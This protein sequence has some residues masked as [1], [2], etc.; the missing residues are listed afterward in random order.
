MEF[1]HTIFFLI[2]LNGVFS[3]AQDIIF[4][5]DSTK[6]IATVM[7]VNPTQIK[8]KLYDDSTGFSIVAFKWN[9]Y[10]IIYKNG[11]QDVF[12]DVKPYYWKVEEDK[13]QEISNKKGIRKRDSINYGHKN[14][15][16]FN[17]VQF[18]DGAIGLNYFRV[19]SKLHMSVSGEFDIGRKNASPLISD[20]ILHEHNRNYVLAHKNSDFNLGANYNFFTKWK[21][22]AYVGVLFRMAQFEGSYSNHLFTINKYYHFLNF[23]FVGKT[24]YGL[25]YS[26]NVAI[27]KY[28]NDYL[29]N[30]PLE[31]QKIDYVQNISNQGTTFYLS[32]NLGY[33]F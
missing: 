16:L 30:D 4:F 14:I 25:S 24:G 1:K 33:S 10:K 23:G 12:K 2:L 21:S 11:F 18:I 17:P 29:K 32:M 6:V 3:N 13:T 27:G 22:F 5:R 19:I 31:Y 8:Y 9:I 26:A 20:G 15:I 28:Y 7:E